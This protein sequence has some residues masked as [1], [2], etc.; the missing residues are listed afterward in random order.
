MVIILARPE[1]NK[2]YKYDVM[3]IEFMLWYQRHD[4]TFMPSWVLSS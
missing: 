3:T 2:N 4:V 1:F